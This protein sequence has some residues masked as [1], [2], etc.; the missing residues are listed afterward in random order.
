MDNIRSGTVKIVVRN[1]QPSMF[2][3]AYPGKTGVKLAMCENLG[4]K[5]NHNAI[6]GQ[7][8]AAVEGSCIGWSQ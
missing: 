5:I 3:L 1:Q 6:Q 7:A 2:S 4:A 8:L